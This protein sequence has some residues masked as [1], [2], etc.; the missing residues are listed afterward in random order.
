MSKYKHPD[1]EYTH[2][3]KVV[4]T[5]L[6]PYIRIIIMCECKSQGWMDQK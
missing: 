2:L 3:I 5:F 4:N 6:I 1:C